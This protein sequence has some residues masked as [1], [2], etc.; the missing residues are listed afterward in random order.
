MGLVAEGI[1]SSAFVEL[2]IENS[3][4]VSLRQTAI[5]HPHLFFHINNTRSAWQRHIILTRR[6]LP[7]G[8]GESDNGNLSLVD[9]MKSNARFVSYRCDRVI[10]THT[11][12][13]PKEDRSACKVVPAGS[14]QPFIEFLTRN[15]IPIFYPVSE[16]PD[17]SRAIKSTVEFPVAFQIWTLGIL[18]V[19]ALS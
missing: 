3:P 16:F 17:V 5:Q 2:S 1:F 8:K 7:D 9:Q 18:V 4:W 13:S 6:I 14:V 11:P 10:L 19:A 12:F 15:P